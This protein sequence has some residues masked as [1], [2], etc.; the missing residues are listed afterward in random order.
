MCA[1][2]SPVS[3]CVPVVCSPLLPT[4]GGLIPLR[5]V[6]ASCMCVRVR[7]CGVS[8][9]PSAVLCSPP[10]LASLCLSAPPLCP[11][12][13]P[14]RL[15]PPPSPCRAINIR[16]GSWRR[17]K[18]VKKHNTHE[19]HDESAR[20]DD[21]R[22]SAQPQARNGR[23]A[24]QGGRGAALIGKQRRRF[25]NERERAHTTGS[26]TPDV[27]VLHLWLAPRLLLTHSI[28]RLARLCDLFVRLLARLFVCVSFR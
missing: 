28:A 14:P 6:C 26:C 13:T 15:P 16:P 7:V 11:Q 19:Q 2:C 4:T 22:T 12:P 24:A 5:S 9:A 25:E 27:R 23:R 21:Q 17:M 10:S 20:E 1:F 8:V 3:L 18:I